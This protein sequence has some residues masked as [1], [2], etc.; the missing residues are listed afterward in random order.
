MTFEERAAVIEDLKRRNADMVRKASEKQAR[1][2][3]YIAA[4]NLAMQIYVDAITAPL[5]AF[6]EEIREDMRREGKR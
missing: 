1:Y 6:A 2:E 5:R 4:M 3:A